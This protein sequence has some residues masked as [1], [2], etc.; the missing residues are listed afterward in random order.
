MNRSTDANSRVGIAG[1]SIPALA[2]IAAAALTQAAVTLAAFAWLARSLPAGEVGRFGLYLAIVSFVLGLDGV[3]QPAVVSSMA[4]DPDVDTRLRSLAGLSSLTGLIVGAAIGVACRALFALSWGEAIALAMFAPVHFLVSPSLGRL[5]A[6]KGPH[7]S[8]TLHSVSWS[9]G[10]AAIAITAVAAGRA[11][12]SAWAVLLAPC[13]MACFVAR[14]RLVVRPA[15]RIHREAWRAAAG[16]MRW[17]G[18]MAL[19]GFLD[20]GAIAG[21]A[22]PVQ[23]GA[24]VPISELVARACG[25]AGLAASVFLRHET[26]IA[27]EAGA[28]QAAL[29]RRTVDTYF[30]L[31]C[32][33]I[34]LAAIHAGAVLDAFVAAS[35]PDEVLAFKLLLAGLALSVGSQWAAVTLRARGQFDQYRPFLASLLVALACVAWLVGTWGIVGAAL[36]SLVLRAADVA[37]LVRA[38]AHLSGLQIACVTASTALV[39]FS[40]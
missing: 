4:D 24:Y 31:A 20:K 12:P 38:R 1:D 28:R 39:L 22:T 10:T 26:L 34:V 13:L 35:G 30:V 9:L 21:R 11:A 7:Y 2:L 23:L 33:A 14:A 8:N 6:V 27:R 19:S 18:V 29:H 40:A 36:A 3:R 32:L 17:H 25:L 37:L 5:E 16:N 15:L